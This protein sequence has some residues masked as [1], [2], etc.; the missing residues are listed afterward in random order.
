[1]A[2]VRWTTPA[3]ESLR[4]ILEYIA[5]DSPIYAERFGSRVIAAPKIL[6]RYPYTGRIV[7]EYGDER[8]REI[9][10]GAYR[11]I[12]AIREKVCY[13]VAIVHGSRD[14]LRHIDVNPW[15]IE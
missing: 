4:R 7:P 2:E 14:L 3:L 5:E 8:I 15:I 6:K 10:V 1:M 9:I 13:V 11:I 12:Y